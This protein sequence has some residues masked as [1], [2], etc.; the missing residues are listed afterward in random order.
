MQYYRPP[1]GETGP[2]IIVVVEDPRGDGKIR[3]SVAGFDR[4]MI[5][6]GYTKVEHD[7]VISL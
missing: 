5:E 2:P 1:L 7:D 6:A 3:V 4:L